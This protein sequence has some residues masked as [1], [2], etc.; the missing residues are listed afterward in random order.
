[1]LHANK[2]LSYFYGNFV[3]K[4]ITTKKVKTISVSSRAGLVGR[5]P[6]LDSSK[7]D[8]DTNSRWQA[9]VGRKLLCNVAEICTYFQTS[10]S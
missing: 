4:I 6:P 5:Q 2:G 9:I 8:V 3:N 7:I 10:P 1:M